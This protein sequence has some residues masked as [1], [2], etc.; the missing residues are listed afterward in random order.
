MMARRGC[1]GPFSH[2]VNHIAPKLVARPLTPS[3]GTSGQKTGVVMRKL[4][5]G[6]ALAAY[7]LPA[8]TAYAGELIDAT[9]PAGVLEVVRGHGDASLSKDGM[10]DPLIE[11]VIEEKDYRLLFYNCTEGRDCKSLKF[12]ATWEA[13]DLT[14][15]MMSDWNRE[16]RFGKAYLDKEGQATVEMN[17]NLHGG[18]TRA[19]FDDTIDWWRLV[20]SEF[21]IYH[22][23][24]NWLFR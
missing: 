19:N 7:S 18:V 11:G 12:S 22:D 15:A 23:A 17:V 8:P 1:A 14:D 21:P 5:I 9:D 24:L 20:L 16:Q 10:G 13:E 4:I 2:F 6:L 3:F